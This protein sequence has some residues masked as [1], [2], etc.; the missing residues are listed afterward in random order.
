MACQ[1]T[2]LEMGSNVF[3]GHLHACFQRVSFSDQ[4]EA[5]KVN[6]KAVGITSSSDLHNVVDT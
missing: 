5:I 2:L 4:S 1:L 6:G 3:V